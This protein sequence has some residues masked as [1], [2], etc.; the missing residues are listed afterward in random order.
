MHVGENLLVQLPVAM[1]AQAVKAKGGCHPHAISCVTSALCMDCELPMNLQ[2]TEALLLLSTRLHAAE[3]LAS[4]V[5]QAST[6]HGTGNWPAQLHQV[7]AA[8]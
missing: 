6:E 4:L 5:H 7:H 1:P 2:E 8:C 3:W